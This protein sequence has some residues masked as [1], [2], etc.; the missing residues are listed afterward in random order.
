M[1]LSDEILS[2]YHL[3]ASSP[4]T[5][6]SSF[7]PAPHPPSPLPFP[8]FPLLSPPSPPPLSLTASKRSTKPKG[9]VDSRSSSRL[10]CLQLQQLHE[11]MECKKQ[12]LAI[13][14]HTMSPALRVWVCL[15]LPEGKRGSGSISPST[16]SPP[17]PPSHP[18]PSPPLHLS[19]LPLIS[20][21]SPPSSP[22][23]HPSSTA[24]SY[25]IL[26]PGSKPPPA[27][28]TLPHSHP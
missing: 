3:L 20:P 25:V 23:Q 21:P 28:P 17:S 7:F 5:T 19:L 14:C 27:D 26:S 4:S 12:T 24:S 18:S 2:R 8:K 6:C 13:W 15:K 1:Q 22:S 9:V 16:P 10:N 11:K